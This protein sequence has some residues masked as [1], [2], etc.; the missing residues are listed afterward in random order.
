[1]IDKLAKEK[2]ATYAQIA[3]AYLMHKYDRLVPI[4]GMYKMRSVNENLHAAEISL[5]AEDM[6]FIDSTLDG[7][8]IYGD[9]KE[10]KVVA[11][12]DMLKK[13]GYVPR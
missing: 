12:S 13:E 7:I 9:C 10:D 1:M 2:N 6:Q 5:T 11:L 4:P 3:L 8:T